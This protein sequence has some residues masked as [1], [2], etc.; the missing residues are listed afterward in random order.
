MF[1]NESVL[2]HYTFP[3]TIHQLQKIKEIAERR[4]SQ[5][6]DIHAR[7]DEVC[8]QIPESVGENDGYHR[9]CY[10]KFN[11]H[12]DRVADTNITSNN[13]DTSH[14]SARDTEGD[15]VK[16]KEDSIFRNKTR[17]CNVKNWETGQLK[18]YFISRK[19]IGRV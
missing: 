10:T 7:Y 8:T 14:R 9:D 15:K 5:P 11:R 17:P 12:L 4:Q 3:L 19:T 6:K 13:K 2:S 16:F 18:V 1:F